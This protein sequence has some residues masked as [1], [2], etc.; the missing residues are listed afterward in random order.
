MG[1]GKLSNLGGKKAKP[2]GT[3]GGGKVPKGGKKK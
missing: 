1:K 3:K 2:F